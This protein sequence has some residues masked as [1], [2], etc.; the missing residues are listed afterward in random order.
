[1][2]EARLVAKLA[3][4]KGLAT[5]MGT[6]IHAGEN[7]RRVVEIIQSG[8]IGDVHEVHVWVG[9][10]W[11]GGEL[12]TETEKPPENLDWDLWLG[13]AP[14]R[15]FAKGRYHPAQWA[16]LVAIRFGNAR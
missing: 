3:K 14:E 6:Q 4:E 15:P 5:Q 13:P 9:K 11:G 1:M 8:A 7:Y 16:P 10:A 12:P 2:A